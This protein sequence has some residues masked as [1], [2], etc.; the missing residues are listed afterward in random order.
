[1][2]LIDSSVWITFYHPERPATPELDGV[3]ALG[4]A[5]TTDLV[6]TE[7]LQ[8]FRATERKRYNTALND[9]ESCIYLPSFD[10]KI[11]I[12]SANHYRKLRSKG[13]TP[14]N[15]IDVYLATLCIEHNIQLLTYDLSDFKPMSQCIGLKLIEVTK[16]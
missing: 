14:R 8:G 12:S 11:A 9:L 6:M 7:V 16:H 1:M 15:T 5:A 3:L 10:K 4:Q 2:V 13:I